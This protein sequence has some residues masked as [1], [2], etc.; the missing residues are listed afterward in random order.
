L[1]L[2]GFGAF[3]RAGAKRFFALAFET[4]FFRAAMDCRKRSEDARKS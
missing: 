4:L 3:A 2:A 1:P